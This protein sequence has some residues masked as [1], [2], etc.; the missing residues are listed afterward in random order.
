MHAISVSVFQS[1]LHSCQT[2]LVLKLRSIKDY[3][4]FRKDINNSDN[5]TDKYN[6]NVNKCLNK[7]LRRPRQREDM[8]DILATADINLLIRIHPNRIDD[9][10][11]TAGI[12]VLIRIHPNRI[13]DIYD[14]PFTTL[15]SAHIAEW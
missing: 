6:T 2:W 11:A 10:Y 4:I 13:H 7:T 5:L 12:N 3:Q 9:I 8:K 1:M 14:M 15:L